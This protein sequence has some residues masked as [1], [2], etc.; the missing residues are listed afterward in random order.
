M[1]CFV[2]KTV[3]CS[4]GANLAIHVKQSKATVWRGRSDSE[5]RADRKFWAYNFRLGLRV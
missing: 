4:S 1:F 2:Q 3:L 5:R